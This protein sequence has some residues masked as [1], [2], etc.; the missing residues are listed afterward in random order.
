MNLA[1]RILLA[2][3]VLVPLC[4]ADAVLASEPLPHGATFDLGF[5][6]RQ[7]ALDTVLK[8]IAE[9]R[10]EILVAAYSF[11][12]KPIA[13]ALLEVHR[14]GI[15]VM[16]VADQKA[17]SGRYS[18]VT[19]LANQ[20]VPVRLNGHYAIFHHKFMVIDGKTLETGSFNYTAAA[21]S[22][23]AENALLLW[24]VPN[25]AAEYAREWQ[26]LWDEAQELKPNY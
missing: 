9:A 10:S 12:S 21:A 5:S 26:R 22:K 15:K 19:F 24:D 23:N 8:G 13:T 7:G 11:T 3:L 6:P 17:N 14:H 2:V 4:V 16:V 25:L 1:K 20:G 18:A